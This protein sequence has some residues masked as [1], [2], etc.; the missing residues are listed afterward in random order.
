MEVHFASKTK[1]SFA[2]LQKRLE[3]GARFVVYQWVVP[4]PL[5]FPKRRFSDVY[6]IEAGQNPN[7]Y[8]G[9]FNL[10]CRLFGWWGFPFGPMAVFTTV[11]SN[12]SGGIDVTDDIV[13]NLTEKDYASGSLTIV[14]TA[15]KFISPEK[16]DLKEYQKVFSA[17]IRQNIIEEMPTIGIYIDTKDSEAP[18]PYIGFEEPLSEE[19]KTLIED[20]IYK[21]FYKHHHFFLV[22]LNDDFHLSEILL[23]QGTKVVQA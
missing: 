3:K 9:R 19:K 21:R 13:L 14:E 16:T 1:L 11:R 8:C 23:Q 12:K 5:F 2:E 22:E 6:L 18:L 7:S 4:L 20:G 10:Y 17:L 15:T